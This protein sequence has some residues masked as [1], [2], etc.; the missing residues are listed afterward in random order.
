D[1]GF[2]LVND[3]GQT[4]VS[5]DEEFEHQRFSLATFVGVNFPLLKA[6]FAADGK[7][8]WLEPHGEAAGIHTRLL[9]CNLTT[10]LRLSFHEQFSQAAQEKERESL[11]KAR[12]CTQVG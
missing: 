11:V 8:Q 3:Y 6:L 12:Q 10:G 9:G 1:Q 5:R 7:A 2:I 4:Q